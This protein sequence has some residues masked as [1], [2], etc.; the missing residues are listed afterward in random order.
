MADAG[1]R[2]PGAGAACLR[3]ALSLGLTLGLPACQPPAA[4]VTAS[5]P[6]A[7][8]QLRGSS[9]SWAALEQIERRDIALPKQDAQAL[10][11]L[12]EQLPAGS[13]ERL[14][15]LSLRAT[16]L[17]NL[18]ERSGLDQILQE[19]EQWPKE[20]L[21][22]AAQL[23]AK[24]ARAT[25]FAKNGELAAASQALAGLAAYR[26]GPVEAG[27]LW[28]AQL[29]LSKVMGDRGEMDE[30]INGGLAALKLAER[31]DSHWRRAISLG[32]L[33]F[34]YFRAQQQ[35][36]AAATDAQALAEAQLDPDP[37]TLNSVYTSRFIVYSEQG[38]GRIATEANAQ[39]LAAAREM[40]SDTLVSL[41]LGNSADYHLRRGNYAKA[42][43]LAQESLALAAKT[44]DVAAETLAR[45]NAGIA[46]IG[47]HRLDEGK[48]EVMQAIA[49]DEQREASTYAADGWLELGGYLER[50]G[51]LSGAVHAYHQARRL[52]DLVLREENR[53]AV[54]E[55]QARYDDEQRAKEIALLNHDN[56]LK[57]EQI[58]A[59]DLQLKLWGALGGCVLVSAA[60]LS[61]A[62][63]RV[64]KTNQALKN[65]NESLR[66]QSERDPLT[67]LANRRHFQA[68]IKLLADQ[69]RLSGTVF[70]I[71]I[72]HFKRVNDVHGHAA[73]D[74]VLIEVARRLRQTLREQDLVVRWGGEEFLIVVASR[75]ADDARLLAQRLLDQIGQQAVQ[76][77][78]QAIAVTASIGFASFPLA[79][80]NLAVNWERAIDLVDTVMYMAK[81]HG[82]NRAYGIESMEAS[83]EDSLQDLA[84]RM[85]AAWHEG[86][87]QL[88]S[89]QGPQAEEAA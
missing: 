60:L 4:P 38:D 22:P 73:G 61:L 84:G 72:D 20:A 71:D 35:E 32:N 34:A 2:A 13:A 17:A 3:L 8:G 56:S 63:R 74:S 42:L 10:Q 40:K 9:A 41:A 85:E 47:L 77:G 65:T 19:L 24:L 54:L 43:Q 6:V 36:R 48:R 27:L 87:V 7:A 31:M 29:R 28:R 23:A 30:A 49:M 18:G 69:G 25:R 66:I 12:L 70:L 21:R 51:D 64:R 75:A 44:Q 67:G 1:A 80:H 88:C 58:T 52:S 89:L 57:E 78:S 81:A 11:S 15:A 37:V 53:K 16:L 76:H 46:K 5:P 83:D 14:E 45:H 68:A 26:P 62:Y 82:R 39:A 79:P 86:R 55:A 59:R 50:F 33:A